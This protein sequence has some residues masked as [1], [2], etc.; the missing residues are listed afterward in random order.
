MFVDA[1]RFKAIN[2]S[3]GHTV[4]DHLLV[5]TL[6]DHADRRM[7]AAKRTQRGAVTAAA[8]AAAAS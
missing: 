4:G 3:Y 2:D 6:L 5:A 1:D 8:A 7:Y